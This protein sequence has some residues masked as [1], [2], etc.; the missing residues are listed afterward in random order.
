MGI[1]Q[2]FSYAYRPQSSGALSRQSTDLIDEYVSDADQSLEALEASIS[3]YSGTIDS[4]TGQTFNSP[5]EAFRF[6]QLRSSPQIGLSDDIVNQISV[7]D[8]ENNYAAQDVE[9]KYRKLTKSPEF[10]SLIKEQESANRF[11]EQIAP[12]RESNPRNYELA[13]RQYRKYI[14]QD[15]SF[16]GVIKGSELNPDVY[17]PFDVVED[18]RAAFES[19]PQI[20][21]SEVVFDPVSNISY[22]KETTRRDPETLKRLLELRQQDERFKINMD[23]DGAAMSTI[24]ALYSDFTEGQTVIKNTK[25]VGTTKSVAEDEELLPDDIHGREI[26]RLAEEAGLD[27]TESG[28]LSF[29]RNMYDRYKSSTGGDQF[30]NEENISTAFKTYASTGNF[31]SKSLVDVIEPFVDK[32]KAPDTEGNIYDP[33]DDVMKDVFSNNFKSLADQMDARRVDQAFKD[34]VFVQAGDILFEDDGTPTTEGVR[35]LILNGR[36]TMGGQTFT[37]DIFNA[38]TRDQRKVATYEGSTLPV[39]VST[40]FDGVSPSEDGTS[41]ASFYTNY[42]PFLEK[43]G[44]GSEEDRESAEYRDENGQRLWRVNVDVSSGP[45]FAA[46]QEAQGRIES[47]ADIY[48]AKREGTF[49]EAKPEEPVQQATPKKKVSIADFIKP[50]SSGNSPATDSTSRNVP[51]SSLSGPDV[52]T[53]AQVPV[54]ANLQA[55]RVQNPAS[56]QPS[57]QPGRVSSPILD[58]ENIRTALATG[59]GRSRD[60]SADNARRD[61]LAAQGFENRLLRDDGSQRVQVSVPEPS[62]GGLY[63]DYSVIS[64]VDPMAASMMDYVSA[65]ETNRGQHAI[66]QYG[67]EIALGLVQFSGN[68]LKDFF[69]EYYPNNTTV[70]GMEFMPD[71]IDDVKSS[72]E[73][74]KTFVA[75]VDGPGFLANQYDFFMNRYYEPV[76]EVLRGSA[77]EDSVAVNKYLTSS[78]IHTGSPNRIMKGVDLSSLTDEEEALKKIH[79]SRVAYYRRLGTSNPSKF[80]KSTVDI[81]LARANKEYAETLQDIN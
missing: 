8:L 66:G 45:E 37:E 81:F 55:Q 56:G 21:S 52:T 50:S 68:T 11:L 59:S 17:Q 51:E 54:D 62:E 80:P 42:I 35:Q 6:K 64:N 13:M 40:V 15:N 46:I 70:S 34:D 24:D 47:A 25:V 27:L 29:A 72:R 12:L 32:A 78:A 19:V 16:E 36:A 41:T 69:E 73:K 58:Q 33:L 9:A 65:A 5:Q 75:E 1:A 22:T 48:K 77:V 31:A 53:S 26:R 63:N 79:E 44:L 57:P 30:S 43:A 38:D 3:S 49:K 18:M 28:S 10:I 61:E 7:D 39:G 2:G 14:G 4:L 23:T 20:T 60:Y 67:N 71:N 76:R 74:L